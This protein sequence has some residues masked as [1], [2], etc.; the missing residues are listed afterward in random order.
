MIG[1]RRVA[2][3][4]RDLHVIEAGV[5]SRS[6]SVLVGDADAGGDQIGVEPGLARR[7]RDLD[8]I[9][10]RGRL[11]ARQMDLQ[12]AER[13]GLAEHPRP[14][15]GV[16]FVLAR[17]RAR[18]DWSNTDSRA[19][20]DASARPAGQA[21]CG[22][23]ADCAVRSSLDI[24]R[25]PSLQCRIEFLPRQRCHNSAAF[26]RPAR[27]AAPSRRL[28]ALARRVEGLARSST[29]AANVASPVQRLRI[30]TAIASALNMRSGASSTQPPCASLWVSRTPRGSRGLASGAI[31]LFSVIRS[32]G[33]VSMP[34]FARSASVLDVIATAVSVDVPSPHR[35]SKTGANALLSGEGNAECT[36]DSVG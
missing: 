4:D 18:A 2:V 28:N 20:S 1:G 36:T 25:Q 16:E 3:L 17:D 12:H 34:Q 19:D 8:E 22:S 31:G 24:K 29:I 35:P 21:A 32:P 11:A 14:G 15:R 5:A 9:A 6:R 27:A 30:S 33:A 26:C 10:A 23:I 13:R 7:R